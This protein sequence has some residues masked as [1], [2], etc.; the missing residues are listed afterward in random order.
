MQMS[1]VAV[2]LSRLGVGHVDIHLR[3]GSGRNRESP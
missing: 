2:P 1:V 3:H